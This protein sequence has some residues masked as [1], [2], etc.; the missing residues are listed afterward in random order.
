VSFAVDSGTL[1]VCILG[2]S[3]VV[4][5]APIPLGRYR[6]ESNCAESLQVLTSFS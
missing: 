1:E 3:I 6:F 5:D 2:A 4:L